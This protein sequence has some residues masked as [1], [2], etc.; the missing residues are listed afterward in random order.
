MK[1]FRQLAPD[2]AAFSGGP[3]ANMR[4]SVRKLR[5]ELPIGGAGRF[6]LPESFETHC[7]FQ[8]T[9]RSL[10]ALAIVL[11]ALQESGCGRLV[12]GTD[13]VR[14][15]QPVLSVARKLIVRIA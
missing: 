2:S 6:A 5:I 1:M 11:I 4:W 7:K 3:V 14:L 12:L 8:E 10:R 9:V 15:S 13:K